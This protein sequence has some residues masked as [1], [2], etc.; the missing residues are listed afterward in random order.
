MQ[1]KTSKEAPKRHVTTSPQSPFLEN[2]TGAIDYRFTNDYMFR[3]ILQENT[4]V[5]TALICSLLHLK[6]SEVT[7][8]V[9]TNPIKLGEHI[10]DK[11]FILDIAVLLNHNVSINLE[12]Q[13]AN[14]M[15]W[16]ERSLCY[17]CRSFDRLNAG[18]DY[19]E[20]K[21]AIQIG[22]LD[23]TLFP[24]FPEF[25][26]TYKLLNV[27]N[28]HLYSDKLTLS[29]VDLTQTDIAAEDDKVWGID[30]WAKL[31]KAKTWEELNMIA[32]KSDELREASEA[33]YVMN[34]DQM[35]REQCRAREDYYRIQN[36]MKHKLETATAERD[37]LASE[38]K[39]LTSENRN[40]SSKVE[41]LSYEIAELRKRL[42]EQ[43]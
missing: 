42:S 7:S 38:N 9:I 37:A 16:E 26:A 5:L 27:K 24:K 21:P 25:Y 2:A 32:K 17:L 28:H 11:D 23:F 40:L 20:S 34:A 4:E 35:V 14:Y 19:S 10:D 30:Y 18:Q 1:R 13:I 12:M 3:A 41:S 33:L 8:V 36:T 29:V 15:N 31:F 39:K 6:R 43:E 22:F